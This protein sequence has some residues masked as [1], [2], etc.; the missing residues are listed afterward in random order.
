MKKLN[1]LLILGFIV[2]GCAEK[3]ESTQVV[4][5]SNDS[6]ATTPA[7]P[8]QP[9]R[10]DHSNLPPPP[11]EAVLA[12]GWVE[13][14]INANSARTT[15]TNV[16]HFSTTRNAC[17]KDA[18]GVINLDVWNS[19]TKSLNDVSKV[20]PNAPSALASGTNYC[21]PIPETY[22]YMND[23]VEV[24]SEQGKKLLYENKDGQICSA[25]ADP[26]VSNA[27][28]AD[29]QKIILL[30]DKEECPNGWGSALH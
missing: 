26:Q 22:P 21:V 12:T 16:A 6:P 19:L 3:R 27:L 17:G 11:P 28:L 29:I 8:N 5:P 18:Y 7:A 14:V 15:V 2:S 30:A 25:V 1:L 10:E 24:K 13:I 23:T 20:D 4:P 9:A